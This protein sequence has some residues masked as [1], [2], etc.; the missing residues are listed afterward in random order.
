MAWKWS[1]FVL[2]LSERR[3]WLESHSF[4]SVYFQNWGFFLS[5]LSVLLWP[6]RC[7]TKIHQSGGPQAWHPTRARRARRGRSKDYRVWRY[8]IRQR[9]VYPK[10]WRRSLWSAQWK[11]LG[12][13]DEASSQK[14]TRTRVIF[15]LFSL[16]IKTLVF[17][18][19]SRQSCSLLSN[20]VVRS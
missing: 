17:W 13:P 4:H 5:G 9:L 16:S 2:R 18:R 1:A 12:E 10:V 3:F 7:W 8:Q 6:N 19:I 14:I 11:Y 20:F 15:V